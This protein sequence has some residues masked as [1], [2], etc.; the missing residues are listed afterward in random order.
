MMTF[1][2]LRVII[3]FKCLDLTRF[4]RLSRS[5]KMNHLASSKKAALLN[6]KFRSKKNPKW[7]LNPRPMEFLTVFCSHTK[8]TQRCWLISLTSSEMS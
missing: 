6:K 1:L 2:D 7:R 8:S 5:Q 3:Q 4:K